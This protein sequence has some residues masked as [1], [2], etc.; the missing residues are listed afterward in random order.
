MIEPTI[1]EKHAAT[2]TKAEEQIYAANTPVTVNRSLGEIKHVLSKF[3]AKGFQYTELPNGA[4][5]VRFLLD[6]VEFGTVPIHLDIPIVFAVVKG[7][8][9]K[10][11]REGWRLVVQELKN[12]LYR[13]STNEKRPFALFLDCAVT[14]ANLPLG[15]LILNSP[16]LML[17]E[18][19]ED[20]E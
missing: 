1:I 9:I 4:R 16:T 13:L 10:Y 15:Q 11:E 17:G 12:K 19:R 18:G 5:F 6:D 20:N 2:K 14:R 8:R 7:K 3:N